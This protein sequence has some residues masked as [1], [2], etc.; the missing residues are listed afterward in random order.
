[1]VTSLL[2]PG[3]SRHFIPARFSTVL[4]FVLTAVL[5]SVAAA[6]TESYFFVEYVIDGDTVVID[7][8]ERVRYIGMDTP[9]AGE[10][11]Y[12][13]ARE[14]N[15]AL[16]GGKKVRLVFCDAERLDKYGRLLA[17]VYSDGVFVNKRLVE[18]G[19][20]R[21][22]PVPPCG[23]FR[24][25]EFKKAEDLARG[26]KL[27]LWSTGTA[28]RRV[29]PKKTITPHEAPSHI[30]K[31]VRAR[32]RVEGVS[33]NP[34]GAVLTFEG[35]GLTVV[36]PPD[37]LRKLKNSGTDPTGFGGRVVTVRGLVRVYRGA[38]EIVLK[39][40]SDIKAK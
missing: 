12:E 11:F 1:M 28:H 8:G 33:E 19:L 25:G 36:I 15:R 32:G 9:E 13:E 35:G 16:V 3:P 31:T 7:T 39:R 22:F 40:P 2:P 26:K 21:K 37:L 10:P 38:P 27:G 30:G 6:G 18:E 24:Y 23:R 5:S 29:A 14:R 17:W 4:L 20:A 34:D